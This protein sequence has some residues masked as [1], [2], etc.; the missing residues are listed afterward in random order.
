[1]FFIWGTKVVRKRIG[2][3]ADFCPICRAPQ[4]FKLNRVGAASHVYYV[5]LGSGKLIG[6]E[7]QCLTCGTALKTDPRKYAA[8]SKKEC[9]INELLELTFPNLRETYKAELALEEK[10][11]ADPLSLAPEERREQL[12]TPFIL[13]S[14]KVEKRFASTHIDKETCMVLLGAIILAIF[15]PKYAESL[16]GIDS[17]AVALSILG[18]GFILFIFQLAISGRRYIRKQI[19]P[20]VAKGLSPIRPSQEELNATLAELKQI[21][22]K[23]GKKIKLSDLWAEVGSPIHNPG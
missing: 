17:G 6:H 18:V 19:I 11:K 21:G 9:A 2:F 16:F 15:T 3:V 5:S 1:M 4:P 7:I 14:P 8:H 20:V 22:H 12:F 23:V 10:V 13:V